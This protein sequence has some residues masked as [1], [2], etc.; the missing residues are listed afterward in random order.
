MKWST[1]EA[2]AP[3]AAQS[4]WT[5]GPELQRWRRYDSFLFPSSLLCLWFAPPQ[6][7]RGKTNRP[8][9]EFGFKCL[10]ERIRA[11]LWS[12][13]AGCLEVSSAS[14]EENV[15]VSEASPLHPCVRNNYVRK[16][17]RGLESLNINV[18]LNTLILMTLKM[19]PFKN[20]GF[21]HQE[22][23]SLKLGTADN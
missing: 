7:L 5:I 21:I 19:W 11:Q 12:N 23:R 17:A 4:R 16:N 6:P 18:S 14:A 2:A 20:W 8:K 3:P 10:T 1:W 15:L 9:W 22:G 13:T